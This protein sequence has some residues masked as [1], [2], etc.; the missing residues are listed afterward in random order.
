METTTQCTVARKTAAAKR[1]PA[2]KSPTRE[3]ILSLDSIDYVGA[4]LSQAYAIVIIALTAVADLGEDEQPDSAAVFVSLQRA[5][6]LLGE[7]QV[8]LD[9][10]PECRAK[11]LGATDPWWS[12]AQQAR[13]MLNTL[14]AIAWSDGYVIKT[15]L[16]VLADFLWA[17]WETIARAREGLDSAVGGRI[18]DLAETTAAVSAATDQAFECSAGPLPQRTSRLRGR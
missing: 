16:N 2:T 3:T 5:S 18:R 11:S 4:R 13:L 14:D 1:T 12:A 7:V 15:E 8:H 6:E 9:G 17:V 10:A